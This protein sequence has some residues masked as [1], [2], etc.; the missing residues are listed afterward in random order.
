MSKESSLNT[1]EAWQFRGLAGQLNWTSSQT[2]PDMSYG[3]CEVS[4]PVADAKIIHLAK[5]NTYI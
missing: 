5:A 2:R 1:E 3:A 4:V